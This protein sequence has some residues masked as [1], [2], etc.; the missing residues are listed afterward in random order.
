MIPATQ[1]ADETDDAVNLGATVAE[2]RASLRPSEVAPPSSPAAELQ[3][4]IK[5]PDLRPLPSDP[6]ELKLAQPIRNGQIETLKF[7][8]PSGRA[9]I[10]FGD[11]LESFERT[12]TDSRTQAVVVEKASRIDY[13]IVLR[14]AAEMTGVGHLDLEGLSAYDLGRVTK[15]VFALIYNTPN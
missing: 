1:I 10:M 12:T 8:P 5:A 6:I 2:R 13:A 15:L 4:R 7:K 3:A 9:M 14:F 11:P